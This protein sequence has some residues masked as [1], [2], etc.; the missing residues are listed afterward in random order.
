VARCISSEL[1]DVSG[2]NFGLTRDP[3]GARVQA[4]QRRR[5]LSRKTMGA[6]GLMAQFWFTFQ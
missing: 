1:T 4:L 2:G 5:C 6:G 3:S